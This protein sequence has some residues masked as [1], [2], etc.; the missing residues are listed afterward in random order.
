[1]NTFLGLL[2]LV[3]IFAL[4][5]AP[6]AVAG[7]RHVPNLGSVVV[8]NFLTGWTG[9]GWI[10]ALAMACRSIPPAVPQPPAVGNR[11]R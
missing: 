1:M 10:I 8:I 3:A 11:S 7:M 2:A 9:I 4:H 5:G 6:A